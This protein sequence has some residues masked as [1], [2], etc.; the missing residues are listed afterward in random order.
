MI[1]ILLAALALFVFANAQAAAAPKSPILTEARRF[2]D[3]Y[4]RDLAHGDRAAIAARYD[5]TGV[6][7]LVA[8]GREFVTHE[9]LTKDYGE[10]WSPP[11]SFAWRDLHFDPVGAD[12]VVIN[13]SF[14]WGTE[15]G[16]QVITYTGFLR[17][18]DGQLRIRLEDET[19]A[20]PTAR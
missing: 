6:F 5:R 13:G 9:A 4:A 14:V 19:P 1:R 17:R 2:M 20:M 18:Q 7:F 11:K 10:S 16:E 15:K 8:G 12:A 3:G